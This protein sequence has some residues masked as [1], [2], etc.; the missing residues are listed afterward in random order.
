MCYNKRYL[1]FH[2]FYSFCLSKWLGESVDSFYLVPNALCNFIGQFCKCYFAKV[3]LLKF[4]CKSYIGE[5]TLLK[6]SVQITIK[7]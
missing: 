5:I 7:D 2:I 4:L 3:S 1:V 6:L